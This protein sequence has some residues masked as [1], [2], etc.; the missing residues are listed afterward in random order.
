MYS[1]VIVDEAVKRWSAAPG[2]FKLEYHSVAE[3]QS[4]VRH[5]DSL[6]DR[7]EIKKGDKWTV[8]RAVVSRRDP[9]KSY[10]Q[11]LNAS[12]KRWLRNER[13]LCALD[14][15]YAE[16]HYFHIKDD[17][18]RTVL[19]QPWKS[20]DIF[21][22]LIAEMEEER[23]ALKAQ[24]LKGRQLGLSRRIANMIL[25]RMI[26][27]RNRNGYVASSNEEKT[28]K[29][30]DMY[31][32]VLAHLPF[33][34]RPDETSRRENQILELGNGSALT[35]QHGAQTTGIAR[36]ATP[37]DVHISEVAEFDEPETTLESALFEA[38]HNDPSIFLCLEGTA[39]GMNNW[40]HETWKS[41]KSGWP[42][43]RSMFRPIF[44]PW[45]V[46][47][48]HPDENWLRAH[49]VPENYRETMLPWA[50]TH[51][52]MAAEYV[53]KTDY[54][55]KHLGDG[56]QMPIEQVWHYECRRDEMIRKGR[57]NKFLQEHPAND[58]EA[59][60]STNFSVFD[61]D[62]LTFYRDNAH[63]SPV[64]G[65]YGLRGSI[66]HIP[67]RLQPALL[68]IN[69]ELPPIPIRAMTGMGDAL[70]FELV[71]LRFN[72]WPMEVDSAKGSIDKIYIWEHPRPGETYGF[73]V[74]TADGIDKDRTVIEGLKKGTVYGPTKQVLEFASS[75][76]N[77]IDSW[78]FLL[79]LGTYYSMPD[80][81]GQLIQPRMAIEARGQGD[82]PQKIIRFMGWNNFHPW[83][84]KQMDN[85]KIELGKFNKIGVFTNSW[86]RDGMIDMLVKMLR[87]G[88]LEIGS[89]FLVRE[90]EGL[91]QDEF[92]QSAKAAYGGHD[93]RLMAL[94]FI[95]VS[96]YRWDMNYY[97]N[98]K[99]AA[100]SGKITPRGEVRERNYA[101]WAY[102]V[103]EQPVGIPEKSW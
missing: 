11:T 67:A 74:D 45:F 79:A 35:L 17:A 22:D 68:S 32:F 39:E 84:D 81:Y 15:R 36:G 86:F 77:A 55:R 16:S 42:E 83:N 51:S 24:I 95:L 101:K 12:E 7:T 65:C 100:Y 33:W 3:C 29:L 70:N 96:L 63:A 4:A 28:G 25:H 9:D 23:I 90:M 43:R 66:D 1:P 60:H 13:I 20:Q 21:L 26:F 6:V 58:D 18:A 87:D 94:G 76:M 2:N 5:F 40:W 64:A 92:Q 93:D 103:Q 49:P 98:A 97:R 88:E 78:P 57:L 52:K 89:P 102:S 34:M 44:L 62:T 80:R 75:K 30:F 82:T 19:M 14:F 31:D 27:R 91:E 38:V 71:P 72:G 37:T 54:L 59:F 41:S 85:R 46:G 50:D 47:G 48:L 10:L 56:W 73:G 61:T 99:V 69:Q 53:L 8:A